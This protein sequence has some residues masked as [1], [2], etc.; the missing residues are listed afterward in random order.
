VQ[1]SPRRLAAVS[2]AVDLITAPTATAPDTGRESRAPLLL[3]AAAVVFNLV[4]TRAERNFTPMLNDGS[5]HAQM[6]RA[7]TAALR[8][9]QLPLTT[10]YPNLGLGS[11]Q[12]LHYQS[13]GAM[14]TGAAGLIVG[15]NRAFSWSLYLLWSLWPIS[16]YAAGRLFGCTRQQ[17]AVAAACSPLLFSDPTALSIGYEPGAYLWIG[18]GLWSQLFA[19]WTLPLAWGASWRYITTGRCRV[20]AVFVTV[21]TIGAHYMTGYLAIIAAIAWVVVA[22]APIANRVRRGA[23]FLAGVALG[24]AWVIYPVIHFGKW[25]AQN[26]FLQ[27]TGDADS[28]GARQVLRWLITGDLF[29]A[30]RFPVI[31]VLAGVGLA[32]CL[33]RAR[34]N[35]N[36]RAIATIF[37]I[38][39]I[40]FFGRPTLGPIIDLLPGSHDLFLRRFLIGVQLAAL[41][42]AGIGAVAAKDGVLR[43]A[44]S[45]QRWLRSGLPRPTA[46]V[47]AGA[48]LVGVLAPAWTQIASFDNADASAIAYQQQSAGTAG[49]E[50][51]TIVAQLEAL[52]PGRVYAGLPAPRWGASFTV[53]YVPVFKY[54]S[55]LDFD[56]VGYTLRT[57]SLMTDPEEYFDENNA[58]DYAVFGIKY[59]VLPTSRDPVPKST[60]ILRSG[61]YALWEVSGPDSGYVQVASTQ[62]SLVANRTNIGQQTEG[63][64]SSELPDEQLYETVAFTGSPAAPDTLAPG[65]GPPGPIGSVVDEQDDLNDGRV[66]A[67]VTASSTAAVV[68]KASFDPGWQVAVD[69]RPATPYMVSPALVAVTVSPG[70][71]VVTFQYRGYA[72]YPELLA[73]AALTLAVLAF[74]STR[75]WCAL[76]ERLRRRQH[77][78]PEAG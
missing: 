25:A 41:Y 74:G 67:D 58:G 7:A 55:N 10:W 5:V 42:L 63:Y 48:V 77:G 46:A 65:A 16:V 44:R 73:L 23:V 62:G 53:G 12:F 52:G 37:I 68:L 22:P 17:A 24:A 35:P 51:E 40:L 45:R 6:V 38:S 66:S 29:D 2:T 61:P 27:H 9:G 39:L 32:V 71:H 4:E 76:K 34:Q 28:Y 56:M 64:L 13:L 18:Y 3:V 33:W 43:L 75:R 49:A 69:G 78:G 15:P 19:M 54:L 31:T 47:V 26:S 14:L 20:L 1:S 72:Q 60:L 8:R 21:V 50:M 59:L 30:T 70:R 36:G 11:P 57:A